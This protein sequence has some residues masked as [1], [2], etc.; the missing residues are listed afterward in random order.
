MD[1]FPGGVVGQI[2]ASDQDNYDTLSFGLIKTIA[3]ANTQT[4]ATNL[5]TIDRN[6]GTLTALPRLDVGEYRLNV[7]VTDG[8]FTSYSIVK[9]SV[10]LV[11]E[12]M[13][14]N[15]VI[16]RFRNVS[17]LDFVL[18]HRKGFVRAI[19]NAL[20]ARPKDVIIISVQ[21]SSTNLAKKR[22]NKRQAT[23][24]R[25]LDVLFA[26]K[27]S[28]SLTSTTSF[29]PA[30]DIRK[31]ITSHLE[32]LES[33]ANLVVE[34]IV[35]DKCLPNFCTYGE[36]NDYIALDTKALTPIAT[37]VT[38]FVSPLHQHKVQ[39]KCKEGYAG[40]QSILLIQ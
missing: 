32:E 14:T 13:L 36:C 39:C 19:R 26:V 6:N 29:H 11:S 33:S 5:F 28:V 4:P 18:S 12:E 7:S 20:G 16:V 37:D 17:P 8:K 30:N 34:E 24:G 9:V 10:D 3:G 25:D 1:E 2:H 23:D 38:S 40:K 27:K 22:R 31:A 15:A 35:R 21:P